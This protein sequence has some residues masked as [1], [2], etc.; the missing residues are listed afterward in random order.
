MKTIVVFTQSYPFAKAGEA[1]FLEPE[2]KAL[3]ARF[4]RI[5]IVPRHL[6]VSETPQTGA[7]AVDLSL[8]RQ[9][10]AVPSNLIRS[11]LAAVAGSEFWREVGGNLPQTRQG[12]AVARAFAF[13]GM[14]A[15][16]ASWAMTFLRRLQPVDAGLVLYTYWMNFITEG[17]SRT[18]RGGANSI[19]LVTRAHGW[20]LYEER[21]QPPYIPFRRETIAGV[22][23]VCVVSAHGLDY[24][25]RRLPDSH[26]KFELHRL[27]VPETGVIARRSSD[28][29][30][31]VLSCSFAVPVKRLDLLHRSVCALAAQHPTRQ[32]EWSHIGDGPELPRLKGR[33]DGQPRNL[34]CDFT[35]TIDTRQVV[36]FYA[37]R[38]I[39]VFVNVS[40][41][42]GLPVSIM[43]ALRAGVP[44]VASDVGGTSE[45]VTPEVGRLVH[46]D[47]SPTEIANDIAR[48]LNEGHAETRRERCVANWQQRFSA[49]RN[50][51]R[52]ADAVAALA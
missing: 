3:S 15:V 5:I 47:A 44:V 1:T 27:G 34:R 49:E 18:R 25:Q 40:E 48:V 43:E 9:L 28:R 23:R 6:P 14:A 24:L 20:D 39:D 2:L 29:V 36:D 16:T 32:V 26:R 37:S 10:R 52:F 17:L 4:D 31:R 42:E 38:P 7:H 19:P 33:V 22:S 46:R 51:A 12:H 30:W 50:Y 35:G 41:W 11:G 21:R 8:A 13:A 45:I